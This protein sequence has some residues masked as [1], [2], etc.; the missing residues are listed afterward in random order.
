M[1]QVRYHEDALS[2][3]EDYFCELE[4]ERDDLMDEVENL[5]EKLNEA[6]DYACDLES[7]LDELRE[8]YQ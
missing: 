2:A 8:Q 5:Q 7:Q 6:E 1:K 4:K 3:A